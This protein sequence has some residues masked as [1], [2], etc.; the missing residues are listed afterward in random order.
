MANSLLSNLM[1]SSICRIRQVHL[2][3]HLLRYDGRFWLNVPLQMI[4]FCL[5]CLRIWPSSAFCPT[6]RNSAVLFTALIPSAISMPHSTSGHKGLVLVLKSDLGLFPTAQ[7]K[8]F[9]KSFLSAF[10]HTFTGRP[11]SSVSSINFMFGVAKYFCNSNISISSRN[12][13][14]RSC[15][16]NARPICPALRQLASGNIYNLLFSH[17]PFFLF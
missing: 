11:C 6:I 12:S 8:K 9:W 17:T 10:D 4:P 1:S 5:Q 13:K 15:Q 7:N 14:A 16:E 3:L 2:F